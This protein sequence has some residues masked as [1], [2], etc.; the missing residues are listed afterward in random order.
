[1]T[2][3]ATARVI[4]FGFCHTSPSSEFLQSRVLPLPEILDNMRRILIILCLSLGCAGL[5]GQNEP[6]RR[7]LQEYIDR[8]REY[9]PLIKDCRNASAMQQDEL[10]RLDAMYRRSR[11]EVVGDY[12][13][14]PVV[15]R[16]G[17]KTTFQWNAQDGQDYFGY[18]LGE[19]SGHL[20]AGVQWTQPLLGSASYKTAKAQTEIEAAIADHRIHLE[21]HQLERAVTEQYLLCILDR[22]QIEFSDS[23]DLLLGRQQEVVE[24]LVSGGMA[25]QSDALL[26]EIERK[27]NSETRMG[28]LQSYRAHLADLNILCGGS[29]T[30]N[31]VFL[32][33]P[34]LEL[35]LEMPVGQSSWAEQYRLDSL[36]TE[37]ALRSYNLQYKPRLDLY[38]DGGLQVGGFSSWYRHFGVSAGLSFSW[39]IYDGR[40]KRWKEHQA[41]L[42]QNTI[43]AYR[44]EELRRRNVR[45][46]QC[47]AELSDCDARMESLL[48]QLPEYDRLLSLYQKQLQCGQVSVLDYIMVLRSR[49]G[50]VRDVNLL[51]TN[52]KMVVTAYNYWNW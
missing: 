14:V 9:S 21:E 12:L 41:A 2:P 23:L 22:V 49:A 48:G 15:S 40:Q 31:D 19:S 29:G 10:R 37:A 4:F 3:A 13:F 34:S 52:R 8:A 30:E 18:D 17:G 38:V 25:S 36:K 32:E 42:Q 47:L 27:S 7:T 45:L 1:M 6:E 46:R 33:E 16:D 28:H 26:L 51:E 44:D 20:H 5:H 35:S 24:R 39:T 50:V 43:S 11:L